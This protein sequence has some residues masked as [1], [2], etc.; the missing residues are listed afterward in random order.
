MFV[1][2]LVFSCL[3]R[4]P[5]DCCYIIKHGKCKLQCKHKPVRII[6][7]VNSGRV[8]FG[9]GYIIKWNEQKFN[10]MLIG[11]PDQETLVHHGH[12]V[13]GI[14]HQRKMRSL[15]LRTG[16]MELTVT[17]SQQHSILH[18]FCCRACCDRVRTDCELSEP[19]P[20]EHTT[21]SSSQ[22]WLV[23]AAMGN[24]IFQ[25]PRSQRGRACPRGK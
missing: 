14:I 6:N 20:H 11:R 1:N 8:P 23:M 3:A 21:E 24:G 7:S 18:C 15:E 2:C 10:I 19:E 5:C 9:F 13:C 22:P 12:H 17:G 25:P 4:M 16:W